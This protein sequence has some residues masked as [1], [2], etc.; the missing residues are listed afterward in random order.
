MQIH[1]VAEGTAGCGIWNHLELKVVGLPGFFVISEKLDVRAQA[2][3]LGGI[4]H[5]GNIAFML[6]GDPGK[7]VDLVI[8]V[9]FPGFAAEADIQ[10]SGDAEKQQQHHGD[11]R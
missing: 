2:D 7:P 5:G 11:I 10:V 9:F 1:L 3:F 6:P 8:Y 4:Q